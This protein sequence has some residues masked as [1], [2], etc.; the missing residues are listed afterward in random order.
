VLAAFRKVFL[1]KENAVVALAS[2]L[3]FAVFFLV[4]PV[5]TIPG[6]S[7]E[8]WLAVTPW[9][10]FLLLFFYSLSMGVLVAMMVHTLRQGALAGLGV[11]PAFGS[12]VFSTVACAGCV[13]GVFSFLGA[14]TALFLS[15]YYFPL[16]FV[17]L[18]LT[19]H[20]VYSFSKRV[21]GVCIPVKK[22]GGV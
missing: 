17:G 14:G 19:I 21:N 8:F 11:A 13:G 5:L 15:K 12:G 1:R 22:K 2:A 18:G 16:L 4:I 10:G 3:F 7:V 6:N 9:W 20:S